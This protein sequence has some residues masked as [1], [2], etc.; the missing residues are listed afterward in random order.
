[1]AIRV[2]VE[3]KGFG[4]ATTRSRAQ[5]GRRLNPTPARRVKVV[6]RTISI[7]ALVAWLES[8]EPPRLIDVLARDHFELVHL[9]GAEN[10]PRAELRQRAPGE[11]GVEEPVVLYC[12]DRDCRESP[13]AAAILEEL[14]RRQRVVRWTSG[15][16]AASCRRRSL[17]AVGRDRRAWTGARRA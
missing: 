17:A 13:R 16:R 15:A 14:G 6:M 3:R 8:P 7:E 11:I 9:P 2:A 10:I 12:S 4:D 5:P 1:L